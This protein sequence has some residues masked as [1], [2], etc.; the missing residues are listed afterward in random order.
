M[1]NPTPRVASSLSI[2]G[3][4]RLLGFNTSS[5]KKDPYD[6]SEGK[7]FRHIDNWPDGAGRF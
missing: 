1:Y 6:G 2:D 7:L 3:Y 4:C 5:N